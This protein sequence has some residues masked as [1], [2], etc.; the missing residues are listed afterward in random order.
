MSA[1][2]CRAWGETQKS[3]ANH[4]CSLSRVISAPCKEVSTSW[5]R[6]KQLENAPRL[7]QRPCSLEE[8]FSPH[9]GG[10]R[11]R[12]ISGIK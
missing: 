5:Y 9:D 8:D 12:K 6:R 2:G 10:Y 3:R 11:E 7:T 1:T 4:Q